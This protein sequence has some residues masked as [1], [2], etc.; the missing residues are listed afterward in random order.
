[1]LPK[2][3]E[4]EKKHRKRKRELE[5]SISFS[6][7]EDYLRSINEKFKNNIAILEF[8]SGQGYQIPYLRKLGDVIASDIYIDEYIGEVGYSNFIQTSIEK[9][10]FR[11]KQFDLIYSNHVIEHVENL[12]D[13]FIELI[14]I[15]KKDCVY[16]F[17]VPTN[18]WLLLTIPAQYYSSVRKIIGMILNKFRGN[19]IKNSNI[20]SYDRKIS[21]NHS[22]RFYKIYSKIFPKGHGTSE[23]FIDCY[24]SFRIKAW[25]R[26]FI[27]NGFDVV[28]TIPLL[29]Y[30][31]SEFPIISTMRPID[32]FCSSVLF[33]L[34]KKDY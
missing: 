2:T 9:T 21:I 15:G 1:M 34:K 18:I 32:K 5:I 25:E 13:A 26:N 6:I 14:R 30:G 24:K 11:D 19:K 16:A 10:P 33:L 22:E 20:K 31:P 7:I 3:F 12:H 8:G 4:G 27:E 17:A 29:L 23:K 28:K